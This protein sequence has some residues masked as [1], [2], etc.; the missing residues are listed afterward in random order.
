MILVVQV[1]VDLSEKADRVVGIV[2]ATHGLRSKSDAVDLIVEEYGERM[3]EEELRPEF[4]ARIKRIE[5]EG[6][7]TRVDDIHEFFENL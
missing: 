4:V 5:K 7:F 1:Q 6:K 2:K 3:I